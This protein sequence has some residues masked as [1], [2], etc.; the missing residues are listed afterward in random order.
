MKRV[1]LI[2]VFLFIC[3]T[4]LS[5]SVKVVSFTGKVKVK[6]PG[7]R[8]WSR[9]SVG[10]SLPSK[11]VVSTGFNS[12]I[13]LDVGNATL[14]V[15]P[16][17]RMTVSEVT[18]SSD[19][20]STSLFLQ[21]GKIK[22]D[23]SKVEGKIHDFKIKS[24]VATA[25]VRG[26][27]FL[28]AGNTLYVE[29]GI[30][31]FGATLSYRPEEAGLVGE[32]EEAIGGTSKVVTVKAG[33]LTQMAAIGVNPVSPEALAREAVTVT[34]STKPEVIKETVKEG[35]KGVISGSDA[36]ANTAAVV[37]EIL[38]NTSLITITIPEIT[39]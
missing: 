28:F 1:S 34:S 19:T 4:A 10:D 33:G 9:L 16:L 29:R 21:G 5:A 3:L 18:E 25:S 35:L 11:A 22:A 14:D 6:Y 36:P 24:P 37:E 15:L 30:V 2:F 23:V 7:D 38:S 26:T 17:T 27:S 20:I 8:R 39:E 32:A 31:D 13:V 12:K